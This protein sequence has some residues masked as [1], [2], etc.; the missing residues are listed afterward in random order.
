[1]EDAGDGLRAGVSRGRCG[2]NLRRRWESIERI[3]AG[4]MLWESVRRAP[5]VD[6]HI[7]CTC[8]RFTLVPARGS[9][10]GACHDSKHGREVI[11]SNVFRNR[12]G[13]LML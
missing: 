5:I 4:V 2:R 7:D 3:M 9:H 10:H 1:V 8:R 13:W 6:G 11:A 12:E